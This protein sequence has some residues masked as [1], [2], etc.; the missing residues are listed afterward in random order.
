M[1]Q[2]VSRASSKYR[3]TPRQLITQ[4]NFLQRHVSSARI[5]PENDCWDLLT[6][7]LKKP[8]GREGKNNLST[9]TL[10]LDLSPACQDYCVVCTVVYHRSVDAAGC[11]L[12]MQLEATISMAVT[13]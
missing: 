6:V 3:L 7:G 12:A 9:F 5:T 13:V 4:Y 8:P 1:N 11:C 10:G 2:L